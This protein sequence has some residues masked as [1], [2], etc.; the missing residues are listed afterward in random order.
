MHE[1]TITTGTAHHTTPYNDFG[2]AHRALMSHVIAEDLYLHAQWPTPR[3][4]TAFKL[5]SLDADR[6]ETRI[7]G[8]ATI[9]PSIGKP[10][11]GHYYSAAQALAW[12]SDHTVS[13]NHGRDDEPGIRYP[14]AVLSAARA[15][16]RGHV[17]AGMIFSET[18]ALCDAANP[19]MARPSQHTFERLRDS[20][21]TAGHTGATLNPAALADAV[22]S[23]LTPD[24][25]AEQTAALIWYYA[26]ITWGVTAS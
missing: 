15:E 3:T 20:A 25:T 1:L 17:I 18:A 8:T 23:E 6:G 16:A 21:R 14:R 5:V 10:V 2:D 9:A 11:V 13:W 12:I 22:H 19:D 24:I 7:A 4:V 26:L